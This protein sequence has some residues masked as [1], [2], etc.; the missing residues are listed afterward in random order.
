MTTNQLTVPTVTKKGLAYTLNWEEGVEMKLERL[1]QH[2]DYHVDAEITVLD[3]S[4]INP[5]LVL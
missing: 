3:Y 1:Y 4:E 5:L 2:R